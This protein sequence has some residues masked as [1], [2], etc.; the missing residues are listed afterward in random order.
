VADVCDW[1]AVQIVTPDDENAPPLT[2]AVAHA[3]P[4]E[5][6]WVREAQRRYPTDM[7]QK[8]SSVVRALTTGETVFL[9][10]IPKEMVLAAARDEEH[11]AFIRRL[12]LRS[13]FC[14]PLI[15]QERTLGAITFAATHAS[16]RVF[17]AETVE[18]GGGTREACRRRG[19]ERA[20]L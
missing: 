20:A 5:V 6:E 12:D 9:P 10:D 1:A 17:A 3:D 13:F 7:T 15:T 2:L 8:S 18:T 16:G 11:L 4:A 14:V 19:R